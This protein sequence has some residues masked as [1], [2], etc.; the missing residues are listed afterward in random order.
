MTW[1]PPPMVAL[2]VSTPADARPRRQEGRR[3]PEPP[4]P[5]A[6]HHRFLMEGGDAQEAIAEMVASTIWHGARDL[7]RKAGW[8]P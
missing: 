6:I 2:V 3:R 4:T 5:Q 1:D 8:A 7:L